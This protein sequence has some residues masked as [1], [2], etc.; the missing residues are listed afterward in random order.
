MKKRNLACLALAA[1]LFAAT[2]CAAATPGLALSA[3][4]FLRT[5]DTP[6]SSANE[7]LE[8]TVTFRAE[9]SNTFLSYGEGS[10]KTVLTAENTTLA[11]GSSEMCY[12]LTSTLTVPV[13]YTVNG[14]SATFDDSVVSDVWFRD[15]S[16]SLQ[17]V[18]SVKKAVTH[19]PLTTEPAS[20]ES[21]YGAYDYTYTVT[22]NVGC[23]SADIEVVY[24]ESETAPKKVTVDLSKAGG[25]Y[26]DNEEILFA[27]RGLSMTSSASFSTVNPV[28]FATATVSMTE[29]PA[30]ASEKLTFSVNGEQAER[31]LTTYTFSIGYSGNNPGQ[32][33]KLTYAGTV[34][35]NNNLY[36][37]AL[38]RMEVPVMNSLGTFT[39]TLTSAVFSA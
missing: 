20:L 22:Y 12:H 39:Y 25:S 18:K 5:G 2:A 13:T 14:E 7:T 29:S 37:N 9:E 31:E 6:T 3:N 4:W 21:A 24:A 11:D 1:P 36:R 15:V 16:H 17:P 33:Q 30:S 8:Y 32:T 10:Y 35:A 27:L 28:K 38:L 26:L 23:T 19:T 34:D